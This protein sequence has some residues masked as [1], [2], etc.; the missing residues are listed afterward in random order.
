MRCLS[1]GSVLERLE[2]T[3]SHAVVQSGAVMTAMASHSSDY[4]RPVRLLLCLA[5]LA[6]SSAAAASPLDLDGAAVAWN[7]LTFRSADRPD[8]LRVEVR[9]AETAPGRRAALVGGDPGGGSARPADATVLQMTATIDVAFTGQIYRTDVWFDSAEAVPLERRRDKIGRDANRKI[10]RFFADGVRRLRIEPEGSAE[11]ELPPEQ[12][13]RVKETFY[14]YGAA[15]A[16]CP[17]MTDPNLLLVVASAGAVTRAAE[18]L[19]LCVFNKETVYRVRL[20]A[21]PVATLQADYLEIRGADRTQ[22][23]RQAAVRKIR[24][25]AFAPEDDGTEAFEF[26]EM[27]GDIEIDLDAENGLPLRITG[28]IAGFGRVAFAL[29]EVD[30]RP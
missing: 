30:L 14:P 23:R 15:R 5:G 6:L 12:W 20:A 27:S 25:Q 17:V 7:R 8:D 29:S 18:P 16:R 1:L 2:A 10:Y 26:F 28:E 19:D 4:F 22:V 24:I 11:A 13:S 3:G 21:A 9:L